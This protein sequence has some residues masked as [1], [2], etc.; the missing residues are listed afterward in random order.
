[1]PSHKTLLCCQQLSTSRM[2]L[3]VRRHQRPHPPNHNEIH[4]RDSHPLNLQQHVHEPV[5]PMILILV[6]EAGTHPSL[7]RLL[8]FHDPRRRRR[9]RGLSPSVALVSA[10][11]GSTLL[12][13]GGAQHAGV[14]GPLCS[15]QGE[16]FTWGVSLSV[17]QGAK[18]GAKSVHTR[19]QSR[20]GVGLCT[21]I[22][23]NV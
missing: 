21:Q 10:G 19:N 12:G 15:T 14:P 9:W 7:R 22:D 1:M 13:L 16:A 17:C 6:C 18:E 20:I 11:T 2:S 5:C 3:L 4:H 23:E 8:R